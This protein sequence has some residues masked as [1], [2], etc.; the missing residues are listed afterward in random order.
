M[1]LHGTARPVTLA[2][3]VAA[4]AALLLCVEMAEAASCAGLK[5]EL[6]R[7]ESG[8][9]PQSAA[10]RKW[11]TAKRQQQKAL[12]AAERDAGYFGCASSATPNCT[13]LNGKIKRMRA[14]L[15][16]I[17]R[18]L[19]KAGGGGSG[20]AKRLRKVR[21]AIARQNCNTQPAARNADNRRQQTGDKP[22]SLFARL[23]NPETQAE[24]V[25]A[26]PGDRE[27][28]AVRR[29]TRNGTRQHRLPS[30]GTFRTLC[31]RT[32][33]GY[34][35]PVSYSTGKRQ[36][37]ND[38]AR[39]SELC[40]AS[41]TELYVYRNPGGDKSEMMSLAGELYSEQPFA[42]R[43]KSE[44]VEGCSCRFSRQSKLR[45]AWT[46]LSTGTGARVSFSDISAGLPRRSLQPSRG[47]TYAEEGNTASPLA[48]SPLLHS[49]LPR[50]QDPDTRFNLEKGYDVTA[51]LDLAR[52]RLNSGR[53]KAVSGTDLRDGL[54]VLSVHSRTET[55]DEELAAFAPVFQVD[56]DGLREAPDRE[57]PVRVVGPEYFVAQ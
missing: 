36:F 49:Q 24:P 1:G 31:V 41:R 19:A 50:Y 53:D 29:Q 15:R 47:S 10:A 7:L 52:A 37:A 32:C 20:N 57:V 43:Y 40:P 42:D 46:D 22:R 18:Q 13:G 12:A 16:A 21:A 55:D 33:D 25:A 45:S 51:R 3:A 39:C 54:P 5:S 56:D 4:G 26:R 17:E 9:A 6:S 23:F 8:S 35:F 48:G 30:G 34:F 14:N 27:I 2:R 38:E 44:F 11:S 28:A